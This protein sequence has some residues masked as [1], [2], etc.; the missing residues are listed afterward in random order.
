MFAA[1]YGA[2]INLT[3][4]RRCGYSVSFPTKAM[5][6]ECLLQR[7]R[8]R[9]FPSKIIDHVKGS[10]PRAAAYNLSFRFPPRIGRGRRPDFLDAGK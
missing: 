5:L 6:P 2:T 8:G 7:P 3:A 4:V 1:G 10:Y 9:R